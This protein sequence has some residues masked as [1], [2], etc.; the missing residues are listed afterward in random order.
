[1]SLVVR[2]MSTHIRKARRTDSD[3]LAV[4]GKAVWI[5]TYASDGVNDDVAKHLLSDYSSE[6]FSQR[7]LDSESQ[8]IV[9]ER[10]DCL[11]GYAYI[12]FGVPCPSSEV[13]RAELASLYVLSGVQRQGI[14]TELLSEGERIA[15]KNGESLWLSVDA[16]NNRAL[17]FYAR[18]KYMSIGECYFEL[19]DAKYKNYV[20]VRGGSA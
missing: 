12:I 14:G 17:Q 11:L 15:E 4:L 13:H 5:E 3:S 20:M 18:R 8:V 1:M 2:R 6:S 7:I 9:A 10:N 19:G 16:E